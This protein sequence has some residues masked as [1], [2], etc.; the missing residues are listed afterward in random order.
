M[1][2]SRVLRQLRP[3]VT[4]LP[5]LSVSTIANGRNIAMG[6]FNYRL[7]IDLGFRQGTGDIE[8]VIA[9]AVSKP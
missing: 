7:R 5:T 9:S 3:R 1:R 4:S 2:R 8:A 6:F